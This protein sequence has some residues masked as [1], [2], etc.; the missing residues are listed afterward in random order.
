M[1]LDF[2]DLSFTNAPLIKVTP[3]GPRSK[4]YLDYQFSHESSLV[5][6]PKGMPMAPRRAKGAT[7][8]DVDGNIYVTG[9][10]AAEQEG[11]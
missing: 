1:D 10:S 7:V 8:E 2:Q 11:R 5:N 4:D 9:L 3:P 6:Y